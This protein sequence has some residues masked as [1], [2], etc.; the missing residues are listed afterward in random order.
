MQYRGF[1]LDIPQTT[2]LAIHTEHKSASCL[3]KLHACLFLFTLGFSL[4]CQYACQCLRAQY[5]FY[6]QRGTLQPPCPYKL[7]LL[8]G[9]TTPPL[10]VTCAM[11]TMYKMSSTSILLLSPTRALSSQ[12]KCPPAGLDNVPAFLSQNK[13]ILTS[14][15]MHSYLFTSRIAVTLLDSRPFLVNPLYIVGDC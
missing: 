4:T 15:F 11:L 1:K 5:L 9:F 8:P 6:L 13:I 7:K 10:I 3:L 12:D 14:S 2:F